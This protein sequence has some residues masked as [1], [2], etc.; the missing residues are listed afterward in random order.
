MNIEEADISL[1]VRKAAAKL[2]YVHF[3]DSNRLAPG[4]GHINFTNLLNTFGLLVIGDN[5]SRNF[6]SPR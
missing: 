3:S 2:G 5:F 6:T 4:F 1:S